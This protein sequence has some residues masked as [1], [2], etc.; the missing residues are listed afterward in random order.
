M[1]N[2]SDPK[3]PY[4]V[5]F[6]KPPVGSR[7]K[8]G[9]SGN[10]AGRPKGSMNLATAVNR[11]LKEKVTII[12]NGRRKS[13]TKLDAAVKG[14]VNRAVKGDARAVHEMLGLVP[15]VG[16]EPVKAA[17]ALDQTESEIVASLM[18]RLAGPADDEPANN[19]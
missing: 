15:L 9:T 10:P 18:K 5:G 17:A 2:P 8:S 3:P 14:L 4:E 12:E 6:G 19:S 7:F 16:I 11:A 13:V 1:K